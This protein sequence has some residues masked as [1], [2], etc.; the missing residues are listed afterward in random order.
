MAHSDAASGIPLRNIVAAYALDDGRLSTTVEIAYLDER[1][2]KA[3]L[4][5]MHTPDLQEL[6]LW[7]SGIRSAARMARATYPLPIDRPSVDSVISVLE[8]E[9]DYDPLTFRLFRVLQMAS[10]KSA[11]GSSEDLTKVSPTGCYLAIGSHKVHLI[12][13]V[14]KATS[15]SSGVSST[16]LETA[17]SFG[18]MALTGLSMEWGE[19]SLHLA[20][21]YACPFLSS[22]YLPCCTR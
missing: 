1:T 16:D 3:S 19:D 7:M 13:L 15:R 17:T 12:P 21:R 4:I 18:L 11:A 20:F 8:H 5:Q 9:K 14:Q 2:H 6:D 10:T 22:A